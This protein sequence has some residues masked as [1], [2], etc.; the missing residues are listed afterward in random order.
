MNHQHAYYNFLDPS[1]P[2]GIGAEWA[3]KRVSRERRGASGRTRPQLPVPGISSRGKGWRSTMGSLFGGGGRG[4]S[5][6]HCL[7]S[8]LMVFYC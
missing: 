8:R 7:I 1:R 6:D 5:F 4:R 3:R 2:E